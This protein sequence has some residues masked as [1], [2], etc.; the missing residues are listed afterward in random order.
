MVTVNTKLWKISLSQLV[1]LCCGYEKPPA[2]TCDHFYN[3]FQTKD[4]CSILLPH[5]S[6]TVHLWRGDAYLRTQPMLERLIYENRP[7]LIIHVIFC[8]VLLTADV[9]D[10]TNMYGSYKCKN[11]GI[12]F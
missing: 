1:Q 12:T 4:G 11:C 3:D 10:N 6:N 2:K 5:A 9:I 7:A 8:F